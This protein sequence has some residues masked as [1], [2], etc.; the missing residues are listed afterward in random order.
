MNSNI[1]PRRQQTINAAID[2]EC[3]ICHDE[4]VIP[5]AIPACGHKFC[6]LCIKGVDFSGLG[7][8]GCPICRG[9][10]DSSIFKKPTQTLNLKMDI[11]DGQPSTSDSPPTK[12]V[13]QE[14]PDEDVKP[15]KKALDAG[16]APGATSSSTKE[17]KYWIYSGRHQGWWRFDPRL[18]KDIEDAFES[19]MPLTELTICGCPYIID[20]GEMKQFPKNN[21][22]SARDIK[23]V[24]SDEF[25]GLNVKGLAGVLAKTP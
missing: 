6:F 23:R 20:F 4:M 3:P 5:T 11:A 2:K 22:Q 21:R 10:I 12:R 17:K 8:G 18:E 9:P 7:H 19:K 15:D 1:T 16:M 14:D 24:N 13:K 25:D